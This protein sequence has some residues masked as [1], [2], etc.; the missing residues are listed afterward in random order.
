MVTNTKP[1][2]S[3]K[4]NG[5]FVRAVVMSSTAKALKRKDGTGSFVVARHELALQPGLAVWE[6]Y[7]DP[8]DGKVKL[9]GEKVIEFPKLK[10]FEQVTL[11]VLRWE[12]KD[13]RFIIKDAELVV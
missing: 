6:A 8:K 4:L 2:E 9:D 13:K 12:E 7:H 1:T 11:K 10:D 5:L 3:E